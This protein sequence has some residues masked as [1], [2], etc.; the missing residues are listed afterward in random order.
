MANESKFHSLKSITKSSGILD[1]MG[2]N[3]FVAVKDLNIAYVNKM[4]METLYGIEA[5]IKEALGIK[6]DEIVGERV[7]RF[8]QNPS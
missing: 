3:I 4:G 2:A 6:V 8:D 7:S 1:R 5:K